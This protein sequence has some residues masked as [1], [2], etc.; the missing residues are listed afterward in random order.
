MLERER[1]TEESRDAET[2]NDP[3]QKT[4]EL[5][6]HPAYP[7][8]LVTIGRNYSKECRRQLITLLKN[9]KD[10]FA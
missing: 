9:S 5:M 2:V 10:V 1:K 6:V 3:T 7:E 8:Q 4:E